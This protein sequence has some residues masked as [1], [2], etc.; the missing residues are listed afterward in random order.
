[1]PL[2]SVAIANWNGIRYIRRCLNAVFGQT[3]PEIEVIVVD[4]GSA[5]GSKEVIRNAYPQAKLIENP[6][7][8]G[9]GAAYNQAIRASQGAYVLVLNADVFL[10]RG[11]IRV[12]TACMERDARIGTVAGCV[13]RDGTQEVMNVGVYLRKRLSLVNSAN[14]DREEFVFGSNGAAPF[15][16]R[17]MLEDVKVL[18]EYFDESFFAYQ[19]DIDLAWRAQLRGWRCL[20]AP[21]ATAHHV[22][23]ASVDGQIRLIDKPP[24]FQ[25]HVLKN[26]YMTLT[27]NCSSGIFLFLLPS[28]LLTELLAWPYFL[29]R[30]PFRVPYL[31]LAVVDYLRLLPLTL[32]KR[33]LIQGRRRVND[34]YIRQF[35]KGF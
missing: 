20:Y 19:E 31:A 22:G 26:R 4:N 30:H 11:F 23:S 24:F 32:R 27:K 18:D 14:V 29:L 3:Y 33:R 35:F 1:M 16:R 7:N 2:V 13:Y 6:V 25:R 8:R 10:D 5:D 12:A 21:E 15:H 9:F 17:A 28:L 34:R